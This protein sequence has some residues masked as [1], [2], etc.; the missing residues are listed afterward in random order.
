MSIIYVKGNLLDAPQQL[1][2]HQVNCQG[3]MG[4]GVAKA[5]RDRW[6]SLFMGYKVFIDQVPHGELLGKTYVHQT[7][8]NKFILNIFSQDKYL[9]RTVCHTN[10]QAMEK[11]F[12]DLKESFAGDMAIPKIGCGLGGGDW[13]I[14]SGLIESIFDDRNVYVYEL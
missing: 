5:L 14:V 4:S 12:I 8:D 10:Y 7:F 9:P 11:A 1:I 2:A 6:P 13:D 3:V